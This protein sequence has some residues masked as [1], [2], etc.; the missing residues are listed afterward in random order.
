MTV[1]TG[2]RIRVLGVRVKEVWVTSTCLR[3]RS[4]TRVSNAVCPCTSLGPCSQQPH[5]SV[6]SFAAGMFFRF[7]KETCEVAIVGKRWRLPLNTFIDP[8]VSIDNDVPDLQDNW[9]HCQSNVE[10]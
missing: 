6:L 8:V 5:K 1:A 2:T 10:R 7:R 9:L 3:C 4:P